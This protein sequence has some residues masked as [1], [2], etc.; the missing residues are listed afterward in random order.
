MRP[1]IQF[2]T[3]GDVCPTYLSK[4]NLDFAVADLRGVPPPYGPK[5]SQFHAVFRKIWHN[6]MLAPSHRVGAP[7]YWES[8]IRPCFV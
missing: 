7:S 3:Y 6:R 2:W 8:W 4:S 1:L 5:F